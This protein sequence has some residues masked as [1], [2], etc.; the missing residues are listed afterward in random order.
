MYMIY[1]LRPGNEIK[2]QNGPWLSE[3]KLGDS[4]DSDE[5]RFIPGLPGSLKPYDAK[6]SERS[7]N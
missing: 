7:R 3:P 5:S 2:D 6:I 4:G 1:R